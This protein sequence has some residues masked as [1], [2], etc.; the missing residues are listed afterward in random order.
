MNNGVT[1]SQ[2]DTFPE[3]VPA[4]IGMDLTKLA[5]TANTSGHLEDCTQE[6]SPGTQEVSSPHTPQF[7]EGGYIYSGIGWGFKAPA[8]PNI[9]LSFAEQTSTITDASDARENKVFQENIPF[10]ASPATATAPGEQPISPSGSSADRDPTTE[11]GTGAQANDGEEHRPV[12]TS[13]SVGDVTTLTITPK[14]SE[15]K[16]A[17]SPP[18]PSLPKSDKSVESSTLSPDASDATPSLDHTFDQQSQLLEQG[19]TV[20]GIDHSID[21]KATTSAE[22]RTSD[23]ATPVETLTSEATTPSGSLLFDQKSPI[24]TAASSEAIPPYVGEPSEQRSEAAF[25]ETSPS[26]PPTSNK[27]NHKITKLPSSR[28]ISYASVL[29]SS[30]RETNETHPHRG[31]PSHEVHDANQRTQKQGASTSFTLQKTCSSQ[32]AS[33]QEDQSKTPQ[34]KGSSSMPLS[35]DASPSDLAPPSPLSS[36]P[37][38]VTPSLASLQCP[39]FG[40]PRSTEPERKFVNGQLPNNLDDPSVDLRHLPIA[41]WCTRDPEFE[42]PRDISYDEAHSHNWD[43]GEQLMRTRWHPTRYLRNQTEG[44]DEEVP[45]RNTAAR[46][47]DLMPC[48]EFEEIGL[49]VPMPHAKHLP[50]EQI[51]SLFS[52]FS[53]GGGGGGGGGGGWEDFASPV[54]ASSLSFSSSLPGSSRLFGTP[55]Q[56]LE[57]DK[58]KRQPSSVIDNAIEIFSSSNEDEV[59]VVKDEGAPMEPEKTCLTTTATAVNN[60][61]SSARTGKA[62]VREPSPSSSSSSFAWEDAQ[63]IGDSDTVKTKSRKEERNLRRAVERTL[64]QS[65]QDERSPSS[66]AFSNTDKKKQESKEAGEQDTFQREAPVKEQGEEEAPSSS[67]SIPTRGQEQEDAEEGIDASGTITPRKRRCPQNEEAVGVRLPSG[68]ADCTN[69]SGSSS[70]ASSS[71]SIMPLAVISSSTTPDPAPSLPLAHLPA[72][73]ALDP[74]DRPPGPMEAWYVMGMAQ[75]DQFNACFHLPLDER[76][77]GASTLASICSAKSA[78]YARGRR[79][80]VVGPGSRSENERGQSARRGADDRVIGASEGR[81][82]PEPHGDTHRS[83]PPSRHG[84]FRANPDPTTRGHDEAQGRESHSN[85]NNDEDNDVHFTINASGDDTRGRDRSVMHTIGDYGCLRDMSRGCVRRDDPKHEQG[86]A[87]RDSY[88]SRHRWVPGTGLGQVASLEKVE[89]DQVKEGLKEETLLDMRCLDEK[90][91][92]E[93]EQE[94]EEEAPLSPDRSTLPTSETSLTSNEYSNPNSRRNKRIR[95]TKKKGKHRH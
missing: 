38:Q 75:M 69:A 74:V 24:V 29:K 40:V 30:L 73:P 39:T 56:R 63:S 88:E 48:K 41:P 87:G 34:S 6:V 76:G 50:K 64:K 13:P 78:R 92:E 62:R 83:G 44:K 25:E 15:D 68:R 46:L 31:A 47:V 32:S 14:P 23:V 84:F 9:G 53:T 45:I 4:D 55:G 80:G 51:Q 85:N 54:E 94:E 72:V 36:A 81:Q 70:N 10:V 61:I 58:P 20:L 33:L 65:T 5:L 77:G 19:S 67:I 28:R 52:G 95:N 2:P 66:E 17:L 91:K 11:E 86:G 59:Q 43:M 12:K 26:T 18:P 57:R 22:A 8:T 21:G 35:S 42:S 1:T 71:S 37:P 82:D 93:E 89:E 3:E 90:K 49:F 27:N 79:G 7:V 60:D 16:L